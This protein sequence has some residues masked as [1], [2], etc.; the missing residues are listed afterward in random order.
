[1]DTLQTV[2]QDEVFTRLDILAAKLGV[3]ATRLW[4]VLVAQASVSFIQHLLGAVFCL[5][6]ILAYA[7]WFRWALKKM[8][9]LGE[10]F[11]SS[12]TGP[13]FFFGGLVALGASVALP[14]VVIESLTPLLNPEYWA[15]QE[16]IAVF[17]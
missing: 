10:V 7:T 15:L 2:L 16:I 12:D 17:R 6:V 14:I 1:M 11:D 13:I 4:D 5:I 9:S 3:T 8:G